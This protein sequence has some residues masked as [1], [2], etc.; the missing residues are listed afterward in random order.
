MRFMSTP[1]NKETDFTGA[2][3]P[4]LF[5]KTTNPLSF[6]CVAATPLKSKLKGDSDSYRN[7]APFSIW[8]RFAVTN[9]ANATRLQN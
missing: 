4:T 7:Y 5:V 1:T 9:S 3:A 8:G 6:S 2:L